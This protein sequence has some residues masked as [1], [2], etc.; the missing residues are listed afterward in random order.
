MNLPT[1]CTWED[2]KRNGGKVLI[3]PDNFKLNIAV[4]NAKRIYLHCQKKKEGCP[5]TA[6]VG[7]ATVCVI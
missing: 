7:M 4:K 6:T 2:A 3:T 5:V 1:S